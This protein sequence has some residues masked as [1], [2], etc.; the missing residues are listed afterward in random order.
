MTTAENVTADLPRPARPA[1]RKPDAPADERLFRRVMS[2]FATGVTVI[3]TEAQGQTFGMTANAFMAGSL[4][5]PLCVISVGCGTHLHRR[6]R[7]SGAFGVSILDEAQRELSN[8]FSGRGE[9]SCEP[10]FARLRGVPVLARALAAVAV[11]VVRRVACGDHSLFIG[12]ITGMEATQAAPLLYF[13][14]RYAGLRAGGSDIAVA[15]PMFW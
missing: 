11:D 2:S 1:A 8:H 5:P 12:R 9:S 15:P 13:R 7:Q 14:S 6:L 3:T 10:E 4:K